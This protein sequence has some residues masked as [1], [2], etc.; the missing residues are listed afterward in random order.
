MLCFKTNILTI[1]LNQNRFGIRVNKC[2][3]RFKANKEDGSSIKRE[4]EREREI[5]GEKGYLR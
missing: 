2:K 4:S 5:G 3:M 1:R